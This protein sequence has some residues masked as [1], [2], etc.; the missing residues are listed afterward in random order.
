MGKKPARCVSC[1]DISSFVQEALN[2]RC[3]GQKYSFGAD[4][5]DRDPA[6][7]AAGQ[8][9]RP[10]NSATAVAQTGWMTL[11]APFW[12]LSEEM[13]KRPQFLS[14]E[15]IVG[16]AE[17]DRHYIVATSNNMEHDRKL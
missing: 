7:E 16:H 2:E 13:F 1:T 10:G 3:Q 5:R 8:E 11:V 6:C 14:R 17:Q 12:K 9:R 4:D 15:G